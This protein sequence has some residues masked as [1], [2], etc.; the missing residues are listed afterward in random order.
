ML[1]SLDISENEVELYYLL[2]KCFHMVKRFLKSVQYILR[3]SAKYA[4]F[5]PCRTKS[6]PMNPVFSG[7]TGRCKVHKIFTRYRDIIYA[8][9]AHIKLAISHSVLEC[10]S[11]KCRG[12]F[13]IKL[14]A[15]TTTLKESEKFDRIEKVHANTF[16]LVK[17]W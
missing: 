2:P 10:Q 4:S 9:N 1:T 3:Y 6:S 5:L 17:K 15:M 14:V 7:V 13:A 8:V 12:N 11:D 16:H